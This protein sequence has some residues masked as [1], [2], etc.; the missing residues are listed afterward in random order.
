M[1]VFWNTPLLS[2]PGRCCFPY[3]LF[4]DQEGGRATCPKGLVSGR[5]LLVERKSAAARS[6]FPPESA[7]SRHEVVRNGSDTLARS[8]PARLVRCG[9]C[10]T[11]VGQQGGSSG[12]SVPLVWVA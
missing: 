6:A 12:G 5:F 9:F 7:P 10:S 3:R 2:L 11:W 4:D 1:F 8:S